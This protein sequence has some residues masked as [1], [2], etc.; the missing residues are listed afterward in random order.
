MKISPPLA[1]VAILAV[2]VVALG[3]LAPSPSMSGRAQGEQTG[4][5]GPAA[6]DAQV[7]L[8]TQDPTIAVGAPTPR[9]SDLVAGVAS[10]GRGPATTR[11]TATSL[12]N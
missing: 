8:E 3:V 6:V 11:D 4:V 1:I 9:A 12:N 2:G 10:T 7:A 5:A